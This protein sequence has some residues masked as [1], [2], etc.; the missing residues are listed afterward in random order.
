MRIAVDVTSLLDPPTGVAAVLRSHLEGLGERTGAEIVAFAASWRGRDRL[1]DAV[2]PGAADVAVRRP[3]AAQP[4]RQLWLRTDH[5]VIER[6]TGRVNAV[7]GPNFVVPPARRGVGRLATVHD[8][9]CIRYPELCT[10]DVLQYPRLLRRALAGGAHLHAV[11]AF[12][13]AECV[14]LLGAP[15]ERVHVVP[16]GVDPAAVAGG[17]P[18]RGRRLAGGARY[19]LALGTVEPRKDHA[20]LVQAFDAAAAEDGDL[21]LVIAGPDGWG[22]DALA[23]ALARSKA[24]AAGRVVRLGFVPDADRADL[25]AGAVALAYPSVYEGFGLPPLE[26]MAAGTPVVATAAGALPEVLGDAAVLVPVGDADALAAA[27]ASVAGDDARRAELVARGRE[28]A[29]ATSWD[30]SRATLAELLVRLAGLDGRG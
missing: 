3:A 21:R 6:W 22:A 7:W 14:E 17:D 24:A 8:L 9:T 26:A 15:P 23:A 27:L 12:V 13:A 4:L 30:A 19:V 2:P 11:S 28:R 25:L 18:A 29:V 16:N 10:A 1:A 20:T 5:P